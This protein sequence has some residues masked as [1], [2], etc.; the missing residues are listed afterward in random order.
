MI[1]ARQTLDELLDEPIIQQM[2][3]SD[4]VRADEVRILLAQARQRA[5]EEA[6]VP[7]HVIAKTCLQLWQ[8]V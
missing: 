5:P 7:A 8:C 3:K 2:M 4:N 6:L 1:Y